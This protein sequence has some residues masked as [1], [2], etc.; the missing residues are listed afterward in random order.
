MAKVVQAKDLLEDIDLPEDLA[1]GLEG[2]ATAA[3]QKAMA[4]KPTWGGGQAPRTGLTSEGRHREVAAALIASTR[5]KNTELQALIGAKGAAAA[6]LDTEIAGLRE[7]AELAR[8]EHA[9]PQ[10]LPAGMGIPEENQKKVLASFFTSKGIRGTGLGLLLTKKAVEEHGGQVS[11]TS[12]PGEGTSF[13][14]ELPARRT[15]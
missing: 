4:S 5:E 1:R 6:V 9:E 11:F 2:L 7:T 10:Q 14:I 12:T 13:R 3:E 15:E 8:L